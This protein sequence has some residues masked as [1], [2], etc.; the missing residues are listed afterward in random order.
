MTRIRLVTFNLENLGRAGT[1]SEI[2]PARIEALRGRLR[3]LAPDILC[4]QEVDATPAGKADR[5]RLDALD[6]VLD[7]VF[8][9]TDDRL[10][11]RNAAGEGP[12]DVHNLAIVSAYS[13]HSG[14]QVWHDLVPPLPIVPRIGGTAQGSSIR[15]DRPAL[16]A[17][18]RIGTRTIHVINV[19]LKAPVA[20]Y[21]ASRPPKVDGRSNAGDWARGFLAGAMKRLGQAFEVRQYVETLFDADPDALIALC[22]D[23]NATE[24]EMPTR[25]LMADAEPGVLAD[26]DRR[27][28]RLEDAV[29]APARY[30]VRHRGRPLV[31][32]HILVSGALLRH[33]TGVLIDNA[34][35]PDE[36]TGDEAA[37]TH[38]GSFHAA[39]AAD[40]EL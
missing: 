2:A 15:W 27:L 35:L 39:V 11:T 16:H 18:I 28:V 22:G 23:F 37:L 21:V 25:L 19:H 20:A 8:S 10:V 6:A 36:A 29:P 17:P 30:T 9:K 26:P 33:S 1:S 32:D 24:H 14:R 12:M 13:I 31:L 7:G 34:G 40:F 3:A 38:A 5:R 4:V